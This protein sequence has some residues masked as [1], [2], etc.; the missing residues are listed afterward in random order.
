M[1]FRMLFA[2]AGTVTSANIIMDKMTN[3]SRGFGFIEMA[4]E[5]EAQKAIE[6]LEREG[7]RRKEAYRERAK[8][9]EARAPRRDGG[10]PVSE[11][12]ELVI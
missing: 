3:R 7:L 2:K 8:P 1:S 5:E 9:L 10:R 4:T 6:M 12:A 11:K